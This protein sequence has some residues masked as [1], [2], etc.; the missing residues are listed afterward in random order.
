MKQVVRD[1]FSRA[2]SEAIVAAAVVASEEA[3]DEVAGILGPSPATFESPTFGAV[4]AGAMRLRRDHGFLDT[5]ALVRQLREAHVELETEGATLPAY[6]DQLA[7][8][9]TAPSRARYHA[10]EIARGAHRDR[11]RMAAAQLAHR[12]DSGAE[13][14]DAL[15]EFQTATVS[16]AHTG[17]RPD[18]AIWRPMP[19]EG[20]PTALVNYAM[21]TAR[22][23][24]VEPTLVAWPALVALCAAV[25]AARWIWTRPRGWGEPSIVWTA[26]VAPSGAMKSPPVERALR[27]LLDLDRE[28]GRTHSAAMVGYE[29]ADEA[30]A[31]KRDAIKQRL[32]QGKAT[33]QDLLDHMGTRPVPP[34]RGRRVVRSATIEALFRLAGSSERGLLVHSD[35]LAALLRSFGQYKN[36]PRADAQHWL[37]FHAGQELSVD[38]AGSGETLIPRAS[39]SI[40]GTVQ[41]GV[42]ARLAKGEHLESGLIARFLFVRPTPT[43]PGLSRESMPACAESEYRRL[44]EGLA[45]LPMPQAGPTD[46]ILTEDALDYFEEWVASHQRVVA[47]A[48]GALQSALSKIKATPLRLSAAIELGNAEHPAGCESVG[49][50][51][52][53]TACLIATWLRRETQHLYDELRLDN[54]HKG[55]DTRELLELVKQCGGL[56]TPKKLHNSRRKYRPT[57]KATKRLEELVAAGLVEWAR[58]DG[59]RGVRLCEKKQSGGE[60]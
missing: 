35:E 60:L 59:A 38:R 11:A 10:E 20:L 31:V 28:A 7:R 51:T 58:L 34:P 18:V 25:G 16:Q 4:Y 40:V 45:A 23:M 13:V 37:G 56:L 14:D 42:L 6:L 48:E 54:G 26:I 3:A 53:R 27:P 24:G 44:D 12:L 29:A 19:T 2:E 9:R 41:P 5:E 17:G 33:E 57:A 21:A 36:G 50:A 52:I 43:Y 39:A 32:R 49:L 46:L 15:E 47:S 22:V 55:D 30:W 1:A 8:D